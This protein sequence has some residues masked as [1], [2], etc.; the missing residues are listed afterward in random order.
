VKRRT[1]I[2]AGF[3]LGATQFASPSIVRALGEQPVK[4]GLDD[5][6]TGTYAELGMNEKIGCEQAIAEINERGGII[7]CPAELVS[8]DSTSTDTG[9]AVQKAHKLIGRD[10]VTF[11]LGN[12]NSAMALA[13]GEVAS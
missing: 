1:L 10:K 3:A 7:G 6:F 12:V 5:P 11:L 8:K 9:T 13:L 2:K 4:F